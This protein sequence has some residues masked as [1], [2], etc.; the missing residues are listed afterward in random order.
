MDIPLL[1]DG[2]NREAVCAEGLAGTRFNILRLSYGAGSY[3]NI[4]GIATGSKRRR[5]VK[6]SYLKQ[7]SVK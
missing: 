2:V 4:V 6:F 1:V 7:S 5:L 3:E